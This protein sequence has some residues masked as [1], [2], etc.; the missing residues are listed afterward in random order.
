MSGCSLLS[1]QLHLGGGGKEGRQASPRGWEGKSKILEC[2]SGTGHNFSSGVTRLQSSS[3]TPS[4]SRILDMR[5]TKP[6][7]PQILNSSSLG[8]M[9]VAQHRW[10]KFCSKWD[11]VFLVSIS[12]ANTYSCFAELEWQIQMVESFHKCHLRLRRKYKIWCVIFKIEG[13]ILMRDTGRI[14]QATHY[15]CSKRSQE[16]V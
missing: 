14:W 4:H 13:C 7:P 11:Q 5:W 15:L 10:F 6:R 2:D 12:T 8:R 9:L 1:L 16:G 3:P